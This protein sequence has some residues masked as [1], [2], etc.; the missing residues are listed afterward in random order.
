MESDSIAEDS[1]A[2]SLTAGLVLLSCVVGAGAFY[3]ILAKNK[4][5]AYIYQ[6][7]AVAAD[8]P[9]GT[10]FLCIGFNGNNE[11]VTGNLSQRGF[12]WASRFANWWMM[13]T[14]FKS[15]IAH[16]GGLEQTERAARLAKITRTSVVEDFQRWH[17]VVLVERCDDFDPARLQ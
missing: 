10:A 17:P 6:N 13:D 14:I 2:R 4:E 3:S 1:I 12:L 16:E 8:F 11:F 7:E 15:E 9:A 5:P